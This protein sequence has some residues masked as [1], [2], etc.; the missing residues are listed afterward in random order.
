MT[1]MPTMRK[2]LSLLI[3]AGAP[4]FCGAVDF[5]G[6]WV[7]N[8]S[9]SNYKPKPQPNEESYTI[10]H[11]DSSVKIRFRTVWPNGP[12]SGAFTYIVDGNE[13][14]GKK[15]IDGEEVNVRESAQ[16][17]GTVMVVKRKIQRA[18]MPNIIVVESERWTLSADNRVLTVT[19]ETTTEGQ[20]GRTMFKMVEHPT[21]VYDRVR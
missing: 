17:D 5:T 10:E 16:W 14:S 3:L 6:D 1:G 11:K 8:A 2:W 13:I 21:V 4:G 12:S 9:R 15:V 18:S 20:D 7:M 19:T